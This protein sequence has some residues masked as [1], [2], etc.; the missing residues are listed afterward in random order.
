MV[1]PIAEEIIVTNSPFEEG[2]ER[3]F[4][5]KSGLMQCSKSLS[6]DHLIGKCE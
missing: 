3:R 4:W 2:R 6:F 5:A 1:A